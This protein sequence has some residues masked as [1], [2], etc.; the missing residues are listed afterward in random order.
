MYTILSK[1]KYALFALVL[2]LGNT[3]TLQAVDQFDPSIL[4]KNSIT[5]DSYVVIDSLL[6]EIFSV[7]GDETLSPEDYNSIISAILDK[8]FAVKYMSIWVIANYRDKMTYNLLER[9]YTAFRQYVILY[10]GSLVSNYSGQSMLIL[11]VQQKNENTAVVTVSVETGTND[12]ILID[13]TLRR[14]KDEPNAPPYIVDISLSGISLLATQRAEY[15]TI[16]RKN[17]R[18]LEKFVIILEDKV[19]ELT[20]KVLN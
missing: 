18:D 13:W 17:N 19:E 8:N 20:K 4:T 7:L 15:E 10:Y 5:Y 9:Y 1:I 3:L 11:D 2:I 12:P 16:I 6:D 14:P